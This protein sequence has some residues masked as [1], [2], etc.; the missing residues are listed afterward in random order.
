MSDDYARGPV[1]LADLRRSYTLG[2]LDL[3]DLAGSWP[4][5]F[6][7][8]FD[9]AVAAEL[10]EPNA[11][12]L[13][14][15]GGDGVPSARTVLL[16][17]ASVEGFV[18]YTNRGSGK[19]RALAA[20]P[21]ASLVFPWIALERQV[22]VTGAVSA[23]DDAV[24]D[25]YFASRPRGSQLGAWASRQ[26]SV[27]P[28]RPFLADSLAAVTARFDGLEVPR[29]PHWGG[30]VLRPSTV[31]FWQGRPDRMHDRLRFTA[32]DHVSGGWRIDRLAP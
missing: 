17:G 19:G 12:V 25:A 23:A 21:L 27:V 8:W 3:P 24:S 26:S 30:Y 11:M 28:S 29:P 18:F 7:R 9:E 13:G 2:G 1:D 15:V 4:D 6:E 16:K 10:P 32:D 14:T 31:E 22:I 5:Q 20:N